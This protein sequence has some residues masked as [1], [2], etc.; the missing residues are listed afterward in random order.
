MPRLSVS[1]ADLLSDAPVESTDGHLMDPES[2]GFRGL[3]RVG[4]GARR[5]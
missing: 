2:Y 1:T 3:R 5:S 4:S